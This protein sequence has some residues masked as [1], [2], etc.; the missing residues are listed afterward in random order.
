M[1]RMDTGWKPMLLYAVASPLW[2]RG[3]GLPPDLG[4]SLDVPK[5][6]VAYSAARLL[7]AKRRNR[8]FIRMMTGGEF[9]VDH[10]TLRRFIA[11]AVEVV[12]ESAEVATKLGH[13]RAPFE[14]LLN[15]PDWL[16][17]EFKQPSG[18]TTMGQGIASLLLYRSELKDLSL[19]TLV[20]APGLATPVHNHL[21][22]GL[23]GLYQG[24]QEEE[25]YDLHDHAA[26][27]NFTPLH[28]RNRRLLKKGDFYE[29]VPPWNDV[30]RV[31][32]ISSDPSVSL[33]LLANDIGC[34]VRQKFDPQSGRTEPFRSGWSNAPCEEKVFPLD[35][36][37]G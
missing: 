1:V 24:D 7:V 8:P 16:P 10:P 28:L 20:V 23:V 2:V 11:A 25:E 14:A 37:K 27:T 18:K 6:N 4:L 36:P 34:V 12:R 22:W 33:H 30:H 32:T 17:E 35:H 19:S 15:D 26:E 31:R 9:F 5:S 13:L 3:D 29:L 21:A